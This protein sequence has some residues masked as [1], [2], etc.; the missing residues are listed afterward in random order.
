LAFE[1]SELDRQFFPTPWSLD[2]W[3]N[4]FIDHDRLL[5]IIKFNESIIGLCLFD[6]SVEDSFAHLLKILIHPQLRNKGLSKKLLSS[7]LANLEV[8]GCL[9]F[10]LEVEENNCMAQRLYLGLDFQVIH[11]KKNFYGH[12]RSALIMMKHL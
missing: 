6:K 12:N 10:F 11:R 5:M 3:N 1:L 7:A 4:L 9:H 2:S 8:L